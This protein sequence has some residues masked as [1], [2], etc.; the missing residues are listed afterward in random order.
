MLQPIEIACSHT[1]LHQLCVME[2]LDSDP[3]CLDR[4]TCLLMIPVA[5]GREGYPGD[6]PSPDGDW[7]WLRR[8]VGPVSPSLAGQPP[9]QDE[10]GLA[11]HPIAFS[12]TSSMG[13]RVGSMSNMSVVSMATPE[14]SHAKQASSTPA[15]GDQ[16]QVLSALA[17][18]SHPI[19][20][21]DTS[22]MGSRVGSLSN[23]SVVSMTTP[24]PS[25]AKQASSTPASGDQPQVVSAVATQGEPGERSMTIFKPDS[26]MLGWCIHFQKAG[27]RSF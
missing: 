14:P 26:G 11:S 12:D 19:A 15:S 23:M 9:G 17:M 4:T 2:L 8:A 10:G 20:F 22:S 18:A 6:A 7:G 3:R 1:R 27:L 16:P 24:E 25:P 5:A 13:S 21:S